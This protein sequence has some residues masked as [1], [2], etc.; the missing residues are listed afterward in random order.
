MADNQ[1]VLWVS[2]VNGGVNYLNL[3]GVPFTH[4]NATHQGGLSHPVIRAVFEDR[5]QNLWIGTDGGGLNLRLKGSNSFIHYTSGSGAFD[6]KSNVVLAIAQDHGGN[7][8]IGTYGKGLYLIDYKDITKANKRFKRYVFK[9][10][11]SLSLK[12]DIVKSL[13]VDRDNRLWIGTDEGLSLYDR[14]RDAFINVF[15]SQVVNKDLSNNHI[16]SQSIIQDSLGTIWIGTW[17]GL[18]KMLEN[19]KFFGRMGERNSTDNDNVSNY[20]KWQKNL[21]GQWYCL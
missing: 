15:G 21:F 8:W 18:N 13:F 5:D 17:G 7:I 20:V 4:V 14:E 9:E 16:Q 1:D 3:S 2:T 10:G 19:R 6:F 12:N 11:D